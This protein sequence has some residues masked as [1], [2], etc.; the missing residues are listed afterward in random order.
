MTGRCRHISDARGSIRLAGA[1]VLIAIILLLGLLLALPLLLSQASVTS[2]ILDHIEQRTNYR[3]STDATRISL[4]PRPSVELTNVLVRHAASHEPFFAAE[5]LELALQVLPLFQG[6][7]LGRYVVVDRPRLTIRRE[8]SGRWSIGTDQPEDDAESRSPLALLETAH[9]VLITGGLITVA[10]D[11]G[12]LFRK[13]IQFELTKAAVAEQVPGRSARLEITGEIPQDKGRAAV[14]FDGTLLQ[15]LHGDGV[16]PEEAFPLLM[17]EGDLRAT[18]LDPRHV[19]SAWTPFEPVSDGLAGDVQV[20]AHVRFVP[21]SGGYDLTADEWRLQFWEIALQ[22]TA[23]ATGLG[24]HHPRVTATL[25]ATPVT[26]S[27]LLSQAPS[28]WVN[29]EKRGALAKW[30]VDGLLTLQSLTLAG[31]MESGP[32]WTLSG[33]LAVNN[34]RFLMEPESPVV[35]NLSATLLYDTKQLRILDL[36]ALW[37]P[38]RI[39]GKELLITHWLEEPR[40]DLRLEGRASLAGL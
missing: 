34:G 23:A 16:G 24:T 15:G 21:R 37:G 10:D 22:G 29:A 18:R 26:L 19:L 1:L 30:S 36:R 7:V 39:G 33:S 28:A 6:R 14:Q 38:V 25:S 4:F 8:L 17:V 27:R 12:K 20:T 40:Y 3:L 32:A 5:R 9:N 13:P 35:E 31:P 2:L 11:M